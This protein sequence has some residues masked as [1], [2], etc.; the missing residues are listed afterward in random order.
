LS[1]PLNMRVTR[2]L[3]LIV[4]VLLGVVLL[5][6][7]PDVTVKALK[8]PTD[9]RERVAELQARLMAQPDA[10]EPAIELANIYL[11]G[12][13]PDWALATVGAIE[14]AHESDFRLHHLRAIAYA[15]R[16]ESAPAF[17]AASRALALCERADPEAGH[18]C[19]DADRGRLY[20]LKQ[21][22]QSV[23]SIDMRKDPA[24]AKEKIMESLH[25]TY[26]SRKKPGAKG[27]PAAGG[28]AGAPAPT[29]PAPTA[30]APT[31][32]APTAPARP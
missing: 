19:S 17:E 1:A 11:D 29:A 23:A 24:L 30:P 16:Y 9:R 8:L 7:R 31:A 27:L 28:G 32:P 4:I 6:P 21:T 26:L 12:H 2:I 13:R 5:M 15:D 22:L 3:D 25:P 18:P 20:L 10:V 14:P